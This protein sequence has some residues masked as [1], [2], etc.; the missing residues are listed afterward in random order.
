[1]KDGKVMKTCS[2]SAYGVVISSEDPEYAEIR[3]RESY[4][5]SLITL[6]L[7]VHMKNVLR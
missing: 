5:T 3:L 7:T 4:K 1:M 6:A 2:N